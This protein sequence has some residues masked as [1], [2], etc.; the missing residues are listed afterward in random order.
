MKRSSIILTL[1]FLILCLSSCKNQEKAVKQPNDNDIKV[2]QLVSILFIVVGVI[3]LI[4]SKNNHNY[5][6][7]NIYE[8]S[9]R[10]LCTKKCTYKFFIS[11]F[12]RLTQRILQNI[13]RILL[14][15]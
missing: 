2:A 14:S 10:K 7:D 13:L 5:I 6:D 4:R 1:L 12:F 11:L 3:L 9:R 15:C 8:S